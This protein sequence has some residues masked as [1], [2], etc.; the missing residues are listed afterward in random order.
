MSN[1]T[2]KNCAILYLYIDENCADL[3]NQY[4]TQI[5]SHNTLV[6]ADPFP[7]SGFDIYVPYN[8]MFDGSTHKTTFVDSRVKAEMM[9]FDNASNKWK[10]TGYYIYPRSSLSK[11]PLMLANHTGVIDSGYRGFLIGAFR[12]LDTDQY[13][14]PAMTRLLQVCAPDLRPILVQTVSEGFF[15]NT[16]R[17][18]GGFGS[19]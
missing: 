14:V 17:G 13:Y 6:I 12:N 8:T 11:T 9:I 15:D 7:N 3:Q 10:T 18:V 1:V 4:A 19:T 2:N 5:D 16:S